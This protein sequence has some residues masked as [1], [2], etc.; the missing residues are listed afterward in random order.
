MLD[1]LIHIFWRVFNPQEGIPEQP[2]P[3]RPTFEMPE[4]PLMLHPSARRTVAI[5]NLFTNES[6]S[7]GEIAELLDTKT[8]KVISALVKE[9]LIPDRRQSEPTCGARQEKCT[10]IPP[11]LNLGI[12]I[13]L[14]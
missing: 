13:E 10:Q 6:K 7:V 2:A 5:C 9:E 1:K 11:A 4:D 3:P 8:S 14:L 12:P